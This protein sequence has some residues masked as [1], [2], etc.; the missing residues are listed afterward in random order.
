[1]KT[2]KLLLGILALVFLGFALFGSAHAGLDDGLVAYYPF[3][4]NA[5]DESGNGNHGTVYG[6]S[7]SVT[8]SNRRSR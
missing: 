1:M 4:G 8:N 7:M 5:N 6:A 2:S 3:N